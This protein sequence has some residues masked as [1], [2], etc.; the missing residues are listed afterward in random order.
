MYFVTRYFGSIPVLSTLILRD[1]PATATAAANP[2]ANT[3]EAVGI[4]RVGRT[5]TELRPVGR[6]E[7]EG[8]LMDVVTNG[9]M[10]DSNSPVRIIEIH[11]NRIVVESA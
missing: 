3:A 9:E 7:F 5:L 2:A 4:G 6:A 10:I 8:E 1:Q 11:G